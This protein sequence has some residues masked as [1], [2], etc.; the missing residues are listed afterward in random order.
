MISSDT[1]VFLRRVLLADAVASGAMGL[2][3]CAAATQL[4]AL[5]GLPAQLLRVAGLALLPFA[6]LVALLATRGTIRRGAV[7]AV[8][9]VNAI[10]VVDSIALLLSG[11]VTP[12]LPGQVFVAGQAIVVAVFAELEVGALRR[13]RPLAA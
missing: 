11:E 2:L 7:W 9:A 6:A 8:I 1:P 10:W 12:T 4:E 5:L 13:A 3:L